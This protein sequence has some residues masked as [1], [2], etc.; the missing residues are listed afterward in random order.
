MNFVF[1]KKNKKNKAREFAALLFS[2]FRLVSHVHPTM[3]KK[4]SAHFSHLFPFTLLLY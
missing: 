3:A 1:T 2:R 4:L